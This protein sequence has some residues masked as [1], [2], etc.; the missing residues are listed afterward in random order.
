MT[1][2]TEPNRP[3]DRADLETWVRRGC[4]LIVAGV[5]AY[6]SYEHQR[7][8]AVEGGADPANADDFWVYGGADVLRRTQEWAFAH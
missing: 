2:S 3:R 4:D 6:S 5:A 1:T 7:H 8:F